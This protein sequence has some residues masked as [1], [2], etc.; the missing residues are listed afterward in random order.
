MTPR[1]AALE[2]RRA[3]SLNQLRPVGL[4]ELVTEAELLTRVDRKY[5]V[6]LDAA[7]ALLERLDPATRVLEIG[8]R[9]EFS[10]DSV[11]F[12]TADHLSYRLTAQRRRRRF[13]LRTRSYL[14]TGTAFLE[15]KT[16]SGRGSTVKER[17]AYAPADRARIT[18]AGG[19][20]LGALL[21]RH[22]HDAALVSELQPALVSRYRRTTLLLPEGSR[23]TI[24][25]H[26]R[27]ADCAGRGDAAAIAL[28]THVILESKSA[29]RISELDR[30]L[31]R[32]GHRPS[33]ISKFG[34]GTAALHPELP[35]NKWARA[36]AGPFAQ[37]VSHPAPELH[38]PTHPIPPRSITTSQRI[39]S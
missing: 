38:G 4:D 10:Y 39:A 36:L 8:G 31:W 27:W 22:G 29:G 34:T 28:P 20:Y 6:P 3:R 12:D 25:T 19:A 18:P 15:L 23:A 16:K 32:A 5:L 14:D 26:L 2:G 9:R 24:D 30:A 21:E 17:I 13:K 33:G 35:G 11:Y 37:A 7:V 1:G